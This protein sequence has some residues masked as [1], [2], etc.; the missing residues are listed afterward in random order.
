MIL[1]FIKLALGSIPI[2]NGYKGELIHLGDDSFTGSTNSQFQKGSDSENGVL[3]RFDPIHSSQF[4]V[5]FFAKGVQ[6]EDN[7]VIFGNKV[8]KLTMSP[9][10]GD[11]QL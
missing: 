2:T 1:P 10:N 5:I 11:Y 9:E 4:R 6:C 7:A 3:F 8:N